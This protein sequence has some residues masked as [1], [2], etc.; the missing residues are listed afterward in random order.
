MDAPDL[1][2]IVPVFNRDDLMRYTF[3]SVRRASGGL[4]VETIVVD[5]GS[6]TPAAGILER[7]G[8][9]PTVLRRQENQ[10]LL[11]AR[12]AGLGL[13]AGR[14]VLFLDS[15]DLVG[16][17]KFRAQIAAMGASGA[18]VSYSDV[19]RC[20]LAGAYDALEITPDPPA[21]TV[22]RSAPFFI[23]VQP[24][25]HSPIFRTDY[26]RQVVRQAFFAP[27]PLYNS[28]AE[29]WFYHNAAPRPARVVH[30]PGAHTVVGS[31]PGTRL[32]SHWERL[33][34][35]SLAVME[36]FVRS[37]PRDEDTLPARTLV[38]AKAF[39]AWRGLPRGFS[40]EFGARLLGI[41]QRL[42]HDR[43]NPPGGEAFRLLARALGPERAARLFR[44][45]RGRPYSRIRTLGDDPFAKLLATLPL[46]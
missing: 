14:H 20:T 1:S 29:I 4:A 36:A 17:E 24:P 18:D 42:P 3:E 7:L 26:L 2:V 30:V 25:P 23:T 32:T 12:L 38:G 34:V 27:S 5:D 28:V 33:A 6:E 37:C 40:P 10:G 16:P 19:A 21:E 46:P 44:V 13:A 22:T 45:L 11:F 35:A 39:A 9:P 31:H 15:D 8:F 43:A 41:W